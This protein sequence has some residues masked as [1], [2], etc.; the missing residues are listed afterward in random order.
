MD[1]P[2]ISRPSQ[3]SALPWISII[4]PLMKLPQCIPISPRTVIFPAP[5][6]SPTLFNRAVS[7]E[8]TTSTSSARS[9]S[10]STRTEKASSI[11]SSRFPRQTERSV[12]ERKFTGTIDSASIGMDHLPIGFI[13]SVTLIIVPSPSRCIGS[14]S[15]NSPEPGSCSSGRCSSGRTSRRNQG[16]SPY[17]SSQR[18]SA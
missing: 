4:P 17:H 16:P 1:P 2:A 18:P 15:G 10:P 11:P 6:Y 13:A 14:C 7:P 3:P 12:P 5:M 8:R 9:A